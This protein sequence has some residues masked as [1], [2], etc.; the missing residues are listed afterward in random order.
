[1]EIIH[2]IR[3]KITNFAGTWLLHLD[4]SGLSES[5]PR[6]QPTRNVT[7]ATE[8]T[9]QAGRLSII[10]EAWSLNCLAVIWSGKD[11]EER[12]SEFADRLNSKNWFHSP[13]PA[14]EHGIWQSSECRYFRKVGVTLSQITHSKTRGRACYSRR[15]KEYSWMVEIR[16]Q[17]NDL[18]LNCGVPVDVETT[19][20][21]VFFSSVSSLNLNS[22]SHRV[23][24]GWTRDGPDNSKGRN[25][26]FQT[27]AGWYRFGNKPAS[28]TVWFSVYGFDQL[29]NVRIL[30]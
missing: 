27:V 9:I 26:G 5:M 8:L 28:Q 17:D 4:R 14:A 25:S 7:S 12:A 23:S 16:W 10:N 3:R 20:F 19:W 29:F 2:T 15:S 30:T 13:K 6:G 11:N 24:K 1:M 21:G 22:E 18:S